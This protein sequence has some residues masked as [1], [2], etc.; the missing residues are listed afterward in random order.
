MT[1]Q[2]QRSSK[3]PDSSVAFD[4][5]Y[6]VRK[7]KLLRDFDNF[8]KYG[9]KILVSYY[10]GEL[11]DSILKEARHEYEA[12]IPKV[13]YVGGKKNPL[14]TNLIQ[15]AWALALFR[16]LK[17][18]GK[19]AGETGQICYQMVEAQ[20]YSYPDWYATLLAGFVFEPD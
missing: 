2:N 15:S 3:M 5:Y 11:A 4:D 8:G 18:H 16:A 9:R 13:P 17:I 6:V 7:L 10:R 20:L 12:L 19:T 14:T 1:E